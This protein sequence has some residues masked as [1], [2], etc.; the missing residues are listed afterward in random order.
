MRIAA[1][2][3]NSRHIAARI[4]HPDGA[5]LGTA[6]GFMRKNVNNTRRLNPGS[7]FKQ[8]VSRLGIIRVICVSRSRK[9]ITGI[10]RRET[11]TL[12]GRHEKQMLLLG[13]ALSR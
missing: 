9:E 6:L 3:G 10:L 13:S 4:T 7:S 8:A 11:R 12:I 2:E 1:N 5:A